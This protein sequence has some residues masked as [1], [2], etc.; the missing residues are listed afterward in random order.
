MSSESIV[1]IHAGPF[2]KI[3]FLIMIWIGMSGQLHIRGLSAEAAAVPEG[4]PVKKVYSLTVRPG[5]SS[6]SDDTAHPIGV[7]V[8]ASDQI[9]YY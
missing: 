3:V 9:V 6:V 2:S 1:I 5:H 7:F 8:S 4:G